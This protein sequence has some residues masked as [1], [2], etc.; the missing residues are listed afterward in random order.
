MAEHLKRLETKAFEVYIADNGEI[1]IHRAGYNGAASL[2]PKTLGNTIFNPTTCGFNYEITTLEGVEQTYDEMFEPRRSPMEIT[3][4]DAASVTLHQGATA[5]KGI[6][7]WIT[8]RVEEPHYLHQHVRFVFHKPLADG[9]PFSS[10]WAS[11]LH[12]APNRNVYM[13]RA[14]GPLEGWVGITKERHRAPYYIVHDVPAREMPVDEYFAVSQEPPAPPR[15]EKLDDPLAFYFGL[16]FDHA[17]IMMFKEPETVRFAYSPNGGGDMPP[18]NPAWDYL[19]NID[20]VELRRPYE[21]DL[22]AAVKPFA[23]RQ[24]VLDEVKRYR[25]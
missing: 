10:L 14:G 19:L 12:A 1:G 15:F 5:F 24:D 25:G 2:V 21:W 16:Y 9:R 23:G 3:A 20:R 4:A 17:F 11:Y 13:K 22:C 6:E 18:W 7:A 8:F